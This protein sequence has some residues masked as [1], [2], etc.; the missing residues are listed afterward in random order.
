MNRRKKWMWKI[1][2]NALSS[3]WVI[4]L[5]VE[6]VGFVLTRVLRR[7]LRVAWRVIGRWRRRLSRCVTAFTW[8]RKRCRKRR[9]PHFRSDITYDLSLRRSWVL[10]WKVCCSGRRSLRWGGSWRM[11]GGCCLSPSGVCAPLNACSGT[12]PVTHKSHSITIRSNG[13]ITWYGAFSLFR[14]QHTLSS[15]ELQLPA[16]QLAEKTVTWH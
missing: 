6:A 11:L 12:R 4:F 16:N 15:I 3:H 8:T 5:T 9:I 14:H 7:F 10:P 13:Y 2:H 1:S